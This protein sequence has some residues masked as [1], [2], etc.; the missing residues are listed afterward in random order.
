LTNFGSKPDRFVIDFSGKDLNEASRFPDILNIVEKKVLPERELKALNQEK[1]NQLALSTNPNANT[2]KHHINFFKNWWQLSYAR[3]D[4]LRTLKPLSRYI[5]CAQVTKR[6]IW[7]F[8]S[9][10][11]NPN[12]ALMVFAFDDDYSFGVISSS[13]HWLW[14][15]H[16]CSTLKGDYRYTTDSVWD[17]FPWPQNPTEADVINVSKAAFNLRKARNEVMQKNRW[18]FRHLYRILDK[19]GRNPIKDLQHQLDLA[20]F[21]AYSF[22]PQNDHLKQLLDLNQQVNQKEIKEEFVQKPGIPNNFENIS[23]IITTDCVSF[24]N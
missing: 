23:L 13:L 3:E 8:I 16:K 10:S 22:D 4:M 12:A 15:Q 11:I 2:N 19:P 1:E 7:E 18:S 17:T 9:T 5:S 24:E 14:F 6:P 20:V 21:K